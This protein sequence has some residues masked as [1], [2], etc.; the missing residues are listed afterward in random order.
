[1]AARRGKMPVD[2]Y[3]MQK[4]KRTQFKFRV[5]PYVRKWEHL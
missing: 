1:M 4:K 5:C 2:Y 3:Q